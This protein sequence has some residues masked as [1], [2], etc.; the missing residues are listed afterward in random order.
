MQLESQT[1]FRAEVKKSKIHGKGLFTK[2]DIREGEKVAIKNGRI[3][4]QQFIDNNKEIIK[5]SELQIDDNHYIAPTTNEELKKSMLY[6]NHSCEP[7]IGIRGKN[8]FFTLGNI[9]KGEEL[10]VDYGT[11]ENNNN[12]LI[13]NCRVKNCRKIVTGKDWQKKSLQVKYGN[14][15]AAYL[16]RKINKS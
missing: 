12:K 1:F 7:N 6:I 11:F 2:E 16:L 15:F 4:D 10:T 5:G 13:C 3:V 14:N 8:V 9:S